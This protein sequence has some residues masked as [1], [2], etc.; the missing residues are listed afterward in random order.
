MFDE[1]AVRAALSAT[2]FGPLLYA[3]ET[4]ST[5][6]DALA[7]LTSEHNLG[8]L[9]MTEHQTR[10]RG[11]RDRQWIDAPGKSLLFTAVLPRS[12][13]AA[14]LW[15]VPFWCGLAVVDGVR[16]ATGIELALQW[17]NDL[18]LGGRKACG[19][20]GISRVIGDVARVGC[21]IGLN[22]LRPAGDA[23]PVAYLSDAALSASREDVLIAI[24]AALDRRLSDLDDPPAI[25]REWERRAGLPGARYRILLDGTTDAFDAI[26]R[27]LAPDGSLVVDDEIGEH[28]IALADARVLRGA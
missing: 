11:R 20:L 18:L 2:R 7:L 25:A 9:V 14:T 3:Q 1:S 26:A 4:G 28:S 6:D 21:G 10:G 27:R 16:D 12:I 24:V 8:A 13:A 15:A 23:E 19:L 5:N 17:P 22:V